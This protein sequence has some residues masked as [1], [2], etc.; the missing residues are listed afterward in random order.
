[1]PRATNSTPSFKRIAIK[2][3]HIPKGEELFFP[4]IIT[5]FTDTWQP[6]WTPTNVYGRMD[7]VSFYGG[8]GRE[9]T[10]G[11]RVIGD[12][13]AEAA[14][15]MRK[16]EKLIQYQ[17]PLFKKHG[18]T[19][20]DL[21]TA[22][23]YFEI[24]FMNILQ[25]APGSGKGYR[26]YVN[27]PVQ[28]N[29]GFQSKEQAMYFSSGGDKLY[30]SDVNVVL[31]FQILHEGSVGNI[32]NGFKGSDSY[33]YNV[34]GA[35]TAVPAPQ[36]ST[37]ATNSGATD[38]TPAQGQGGNRVNNAS[39]QK[40]IVTDSALAAARHKR[41]KIGLEKNKQRELALAEHGHSVESM[42]FKGLDKPREMKTYDGPGIDQLAEGVKG[43]I[44]NVLGKKQKAA[45]AKKMS[46]PESQT[47][48][49]GQEA[50]K[51]VYQAHGLKT[52]T[53]PE[54]KKQ[55]CKDAQ[56]AGDLITMK[57]FGCI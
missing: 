17:Y 26:G 49:K 30:F 34:G 22:P 38:S 3:L 46:A 19:S 6:R 33:P 16:L 10:L 54:D 42:K 41:D 2:P 47:T 13:E 55:F 48:T 29:P 14:E 44:E 37:G 11:F 24:K 8:T 1:M 18:Q 45:K 20:L 35:G 52:L 51:A 5:E 36:G 31:R 25:N 9:L 15:N 53:N 28:I 40:V 43:D 12:Y 32:N 4:S 27:G 39:G 50:G 56:K 57:D 21:L 7:P 23:P